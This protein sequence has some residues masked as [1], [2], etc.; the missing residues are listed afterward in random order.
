MRKL[1]RIFHE[2]TACGPLG[3]TS[4]VGRER[5]ARVVETTGWTLDIW[6]MR[7]GGERPFDC[8][9]GDGGR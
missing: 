7:W 4:T 1:A 5:V 8:V 6:T 9:H 2:G 3:V